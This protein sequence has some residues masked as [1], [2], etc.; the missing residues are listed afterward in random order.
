MF[1]KIVNSVMVVSLSAISLFSWDLF[2]SGNS[3]F[4]FGEPDFPS[5][6]AKRD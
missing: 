4:L 6:L 5:E 1:K 3:L 2:G